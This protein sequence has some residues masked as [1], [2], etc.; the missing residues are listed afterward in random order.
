MAPGDMSIAA[1]LARAGS[2]ERL[3][4]LALATPQGHQLKNE[5]IAA[6]VSITAEKV[7]APAFSPPDSSQ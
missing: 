3:G 7:M 1:F 5:V 4:P 6:G 2:L